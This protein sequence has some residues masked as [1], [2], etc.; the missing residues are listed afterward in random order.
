MKSTSQI[1]T[2]FD[3]KQSSMYSPIP[4]KKKV[5]SNRAC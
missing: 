2:A 4:I 5:A 1:L 3:N